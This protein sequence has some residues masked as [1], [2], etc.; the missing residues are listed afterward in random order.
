[1]SIAGNETDLTT[2]GSPIPLFKLTPGVTASS[3]GIACAEVSG[4][5][6]IRPPHLYIQ[7]AK[8]YLLLFYKGHQIARHLE[9][10]SEHGHGR[11]GWWPIF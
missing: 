3:H 4:E 2:T 1:M 6:G 10:I 9:H 8:P 7:H 5:S 11:E